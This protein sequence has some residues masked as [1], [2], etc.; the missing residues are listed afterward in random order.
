MAFE[1][2][3]QNYFFCG[4]YSKK[5]KKKNKFTFCIDDSAEKSSQVLF[6]PIKE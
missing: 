1:P 3:V 6:L 4:S 5:K 2:G